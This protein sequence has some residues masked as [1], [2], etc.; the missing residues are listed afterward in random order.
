MFKRLFLI[1]DS[2]TLNQWNFGQRKSK[3]GLL[4]QVTGLGIMPRNFSRVLN[5]AEKNDAAKRISELLS[6]RHSTWVCLIEIILVLLNFFKAF[7]LVAFCY[8][9]KA[10]KALCNE[11]DSELPVVC[12]PHQDGEISLSVFPNGT[13][14]ELADLFS[15]FN[16]ERQA[17]K[18]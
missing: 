15:I 16:A 6:G 11:L 1:C 2:H 5:V 3:V 18:L 4:S 9:D 12:V 8:F 7:F 10:M 17:E 13:A 14:I